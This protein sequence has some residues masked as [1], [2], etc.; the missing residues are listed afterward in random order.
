MAGGRPTI[1]RGRRFKG[2][3]PTPA[4]FAKGRGAAGR[5]IC[6]HCPYIRCV[7]WRSKRRGDRDGR[8]RGGAVDRGVGHLLDAVAS[9]QAAGPA[10]LFALRPRPAAAGTFYT[11]ACLIVTPTSC[12]VHRFS[13]DNASKTPRRSG[14][15]ATGIPAGPGKQSSDKRWRYGNPSRGPPL[16]RLRRSEASRTRSLPLPGIGRTCDGRRL[17]STPLHL[18]KRGHCCPVRRAWIIQTSCLDKGL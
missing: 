16:P 8:S 7:V 2:P 3:A 4:P 18:D 13:A 15:T 11:P 17:R 5:T 6:P 12:M 9:R 10:A 1:L 14:G